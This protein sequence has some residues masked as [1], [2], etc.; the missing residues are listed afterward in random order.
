[1]S[2]RYTKAGWLFTVTFVILTFGCSTLPSDNG[3]SET[4]SRTT[5]ERPAKYTYAIEL[6]KRKE[7]DKAYDVFISLEKKYPNVDLYTN[8]AII[9]L[10]KKN[11]DKAKLYVEKSIAL[12]LDSHILQNIYGV[13]LRNI[14]SFDAA[15]KAYSASITKNANYADAY[16]NLAIL[17]DIYIDSPSKALPYYEK[18]KELS[19]ND[20]KIDKWIIEIKRRIK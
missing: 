1:M 17:Y 18:Y 6:M 20:E 3:G 2:T 9:Y 8:I 5:K 10:N 19:S 16:L 7:Y 11:Y 14:G 13:V 4:V 12:G 15:L